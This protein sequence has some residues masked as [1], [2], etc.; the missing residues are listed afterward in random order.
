MT[1]VTD[2]IT[3][4]PARDV[5]NLTADETAAHYTGSGWKLARF[6]DGRLAGFFDPM[7]VPSQDSIQAM[8]DEALDAAVAWIAN[9][10]GEVWL[11]M[12]SCGQLCAP[13]RITLTDA[14]AMANMARLFAE[15]FSEL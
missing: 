7:D 8:A 15:Q 12:C 14:S 2:R 9:A 5:I 10:T 3:E 13:R 1:T 4:A 11:V 6:E